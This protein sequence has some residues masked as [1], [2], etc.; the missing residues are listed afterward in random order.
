MATCREADHAEP[1]RIDLQL[2]GARRGSSHRAL[3][4]LDRRQAAVRP[5]FGGEPIGQDEDRRLLRIEALGCVEP[6]VLHG[7]EFVSAAG[8]GE[9]RRAVG[10][11]RAEDMDFGHGDA[12][13]PQLAVGRRIVHRP[14]GDDRSGRARR[15]A[16]PAIGG[17]APLEAT[18]RHRDQTRRRWRPA[19]RRQRR[20]SRLRC[21]GGARDAFFRHSASRG[22]TARVKAF[23]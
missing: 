13:D 9:E 12:P 21:R 10:V 3:R 4:I 17:S 19:Q 8:D 11:S 1:R 16:G 20:S 15:A 14:V 6:L 23:A 5:A 18:V 2:G 7:Q 22:L